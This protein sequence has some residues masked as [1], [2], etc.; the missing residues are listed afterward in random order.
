V[1]HQVLYSHRCAA[2]CAV[3]TTA[4]WR[5][6]KASGV[7]GVLAGY[8]DVSGVQPVDGL[9][10]QV[11]PKS[12]KSPAPSVTT[13][14]PLA[15]VVSLYGTASGTTFTGDATTTTRVSAAD[16]AGTYR[17][18]T[19]LADRGQTEAGATGVRTGTFRAS[20]SNVTI[21]VALRPI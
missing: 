8:R 1:V 4:T 3:G 19:G 11:N 21:T 6:S 15:R 7:S 12:T 17:S 14:S 10:S 5:L 13:T 20:A 18:T 16:S 2:S 9:G